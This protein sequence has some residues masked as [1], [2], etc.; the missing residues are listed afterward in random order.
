MLLGSLLAGRT[1]LALN[2]Y[3]EPQAILI[4]DGNDQRVRQGAVFAGQYPNLPIW[5]S[6]YCSKRHE[7]LTAFADAHVNERVNYDLRATDTVTHFTTLADDFVA[8]DIHHVYLVT[9]DYHMV[10]ARAIASIIFGRHGI[11]IAP[12]ALP[13]KL[14]PPNESWLKVI[15]DGTRSVMW[16][17]TNHS[18]ARFNGRH[19][20]QC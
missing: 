4:L 10:R 13:S 6:G 3:P 16:L 15:R 2:Q 1:F 9:S 11:A 14:Q 12:I 17:A 19:Q 7:V 18:G 8:Q 5:I 20:D